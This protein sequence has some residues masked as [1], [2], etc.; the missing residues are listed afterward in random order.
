M[1]RAAVAEKGPVVFIGILLELTV[2][3]P[4]VR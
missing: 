3:F 4:G 2:V 1:S